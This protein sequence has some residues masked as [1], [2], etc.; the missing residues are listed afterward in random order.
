MEFAQELAIAA[1]Q[2]SSLWGARAPRNLFH[3]ENAMEAQ[4]FEHG[5]NRRL[6]IAQDHFRSVVWEFAVNAEK[7]SHPGAV[8]KLDGAEIHFRASDPGIHPVFE[9]VFDGGGRIGVESGKVHRDVQGI[10]R[11]ICL[12]IIGHTAFLPRSEDYAMRNQRLPAG[13]GVIFPAR[14]DP[15]AVLFIF[16]ICDKN[17]RR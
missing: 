4:E 13:A 12:E 10:A 6:D 7:K 2:I 9:M 1:A 14:R 8:D 11:D 17:A 15:A 16:G 5:L 3:L